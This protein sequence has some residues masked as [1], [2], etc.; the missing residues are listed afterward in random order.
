M[1]ALGIGEGVGVFLGGMGLAGALGEGG[2]GIGRQGCRRRFWDMQVLHR[3]EAT[4]RPRIFEHP[5]LLLTK[6][7]RM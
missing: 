4:P 2:D 7:P 6:E 5:P 3:V 1:S